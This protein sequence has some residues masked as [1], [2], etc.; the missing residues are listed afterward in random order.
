M[1]AFSSAM[2][3]P[4]TIGSVFKGTTELPQILLKVAQT[5]WDSFFNFQ[6]KWL[7]RV[8]KI[9]E[10]TQAYTFE[11]LD[12]DPFKLWL[13]LY[14]TEFSRFFNIPQLGLT[15]Y[16]HEKMNRTIDTFNIFQAQMAKFIRL[17]Y[18]PAEKSFLVLQEKLSELAD[19][20]ELPED[21]KAYYQMWIKILEGH[22]MTL[23]QSPEYTQA[24]NKT[25]ESLSDF[26]AAKKETF[27][28]LLNMFPVPT[29]KD[30]D[31]LYRE[32]YVLKK[33]I[34]ALEKAKPK[35]SA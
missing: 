8:G 32:I 35:K 1:E 12:E 28:D 16:Y 15:R 30:V 10:T 25:L 27:Q 23:F 22:Y 33:K 2:H 34:K 6:Q 31:E 11:N 26:S 5:G 24:M 9:G 7:E 18:L 17:L 19:Q 13:E 20:G 21:S 14:E 3:E 29:Q 4:E